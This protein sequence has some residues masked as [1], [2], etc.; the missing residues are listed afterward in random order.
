MPSSN[1]LVFLASFIV[2]NGLEDLF[3]N[4]ALLGQLGL[5]KDFASRKPKCI[6]NY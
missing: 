5:T 1:V 4:K 6:K 2:S 3:R